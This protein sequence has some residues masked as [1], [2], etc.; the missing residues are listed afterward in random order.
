VEGG[1][2]LALD[3]TGSRAP[4]SY[5]AAL[6]LEW[7][8]VKGKISVVE[9]IVT[10]RVR[11]SVSSILVYL[12]QLAFQE[13]VRLPPLALVAQPVARTFDDRAQ[14]RLADDRRIIGDVD[15]VLVRIDLDVLYSRERAEVRLQ[16]PPIF[17]VGDIRAGEGEV[18]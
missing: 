16:A 11:L 18:L 6:L 1:V 5:A 3:R 15:S 13:L 4:A 8:Q 7:P 2:G 10:G 12:G 14:A 9:L 17:A